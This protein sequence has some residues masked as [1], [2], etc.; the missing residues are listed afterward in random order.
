MNADEAERVAIDDEPE[1]EGLERVD[2]GDVRYKLGSDPSPWST[3]VTTDTAG[4]FGL[5]RVG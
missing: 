2:R 3:G 1:C 4:R 5:P